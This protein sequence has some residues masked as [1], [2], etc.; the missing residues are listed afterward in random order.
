MLFFFDKAGSIRSNKRFPDQESLFRK[1]MA[2]KYLNQS[3]NIEK[4]V[5]KSWECPIFDLSQS[6]WIAGKY[7]LIWF[8]YFFLAWNFCVSFKI[9]YQRL[10]LDS[11]LLIVLL[12]LSIGSFDHKITHKRLIYEKRWAQKSRKLK[13]SG[14]WSRETLKT[15]RDPL[16]FSTS[17]LMTN[18]HHDKAS[19]D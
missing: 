10:F 6:F 12:S 16:S 4:E 3:W 17:C 9:S 1:P 11:F 15:Q 2:I 14:L 13:F 7:S 8:S 18:H 19:P 5:L